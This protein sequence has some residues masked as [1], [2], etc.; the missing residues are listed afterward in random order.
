M[1]RPLTLDDV[2]IDNRFQICAAPLWA[3]EEK[4]DHGLCEPPGVWEPLESHLEQLK[5]EKEAARQREKDEEIAYWKAIQDDPN[6]DEEDRSQARE[7]LHLIRR[8][9]LMA[10]SFRNT[11]EEYSFHWGKRCCAVCNQWFWAR[12]GIQTC[13]N[14]CNKVRRDKTRIRGDR[15]P[16]DHTPKPCQHCGERFVPT[17]SDARYCSTRCRVAAHRANGPTT[18]ESAQ[19]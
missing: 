10:M 14:Q 16:A 8:V 11:I 5:Q 2:R 9:D 19:P 13:S 4:K 18:G 1:T 6:T 3:L 12:S 15:K 17:R 7:Q